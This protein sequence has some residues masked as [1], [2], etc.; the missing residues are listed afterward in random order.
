[1]KTVNPSARAALPPTETPSRPDHRPLR[2]VLEPA[3]AS[4]SLNSSPGSPLAPATRKRRST[5]NSQS[6]APL[7]PSIP[8]KAGV[9]I[10]DGVVKKQRRKRTASQTLVP[11][12]LCI[13]S[14][15]PETPL[16]SSCSL[17]PSTPCSTL[18]TPSLGMCPS[19]ASF[20]RSE[21]RLHCCNS[22]FTFSEFIVHNKD[23]HLGCVPS[24]VSG[25]K[26]LMS[27]LLTDTVFTSQQTRR[28]AN[29][30]N[31]ALP[32]KRHGLQRSHVL[33][34]PSKGSSDLPLSRSTSFITD[35]DDDEDDDSLPPLIQAH[36]DSTSVP[37]EDSV[38]HIDVIQWTRPP[39]PQETGSLFSAMLLKSSF[40]KSS[41]LGSSKALKD[42][43]PMLPPPLL[44]SLSNLST[45][46][47]VSSTNSLYNFFCDSPRLE[48]SISSARYEYSCED[49]VLLTSTPQPTSCNDPSHAHGFNV[50]PCLNTTAKTGPCESPATVSAQHTPCSTESLLETPVLQPGTMNMASISSAESVQQSGS[51]GNAL[52]TG[53]RQRV[54]PETP[55]SKSKRMSAN[56]SPSKKN[57]TKSNAVAG[58]TSNTVTPGSG[59]PS[60]RK[61]PIASKDMKALAVT[62]AALELRRKLLLGD[63]IASVCEAAVVEAA[64]TAAAAAAAA[65]AAG[66]ELIEVK[67]EGARFD[68]DRE[69][70]T[71][72]IR[73]GMV[74]DIKPVGLGAANINRRNS[75]R[76]SV[77]S[78][79]SHVALVGNESR[80]DSLQSLESMTSASTANE[81]SLS[82][83]DLLMD[84]DLD[85]NQPADSC[86]NTSTD[87]KGKE[88]CLLEL[89]ESATDQPQ[90]PEAEE[91]AATDGP[92]NALTEA[93]IQ[94]IADISAGSELDVTDGPGP[95][96]E[97]DV[98]TYVMMMM[99]T[100]NFAE[101]VTEGIF[102]GTSDAASM[103]F[104]VEGVKTECGDQWQ[105]LLKFEDADEPD[106][107]EKDAFDTVAFQESMTANDANPV[108]SDILL[109][110]DTIDFSEFPVWDGDEF[111]VAF[112]EAME[113]V[114]S[115]SRVTEPTR[116]EN[117]MALSATLY[118]SANGVVPP[119]QQKQMQMMKYMYGRTT[120]LDAAAS[121][122]VVDTCEV[123][124]V[125]AVKDLMPMEEDVQET[126]EDSGE[127]DHELEQDPNQDEA[128]ARIDGDVVE[129]ETEEE[130][131]EEEE[132]VDLTT[133]V[134]TIDEVTGKKT[135]YCPYPSCSKSYIS[136]PGYRYHLGVH[137]REMFKKG[138]GSKKDIF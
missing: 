56:L 94:A 36:A 74:F 116:P 14:V 84:D 89:P 71:P 24:T 138:R 127:L 15:G 12:S 41:S 6:S 110:A 65:A 88:E 111:D 26:D 64:A 93:E 17:L 43:A 113:L 29:T 55:C 46:S 60:A 120:G 115:E 68:S 9:R 109:G 76:D 57:A 82:T 40:Q 33:R 72:V 66:H 35:D 129:R 80:A 27:A 79:W 92:A 130:D 13:S 4:A 131:E 20:T 77:S 37:P 75:R 16:S 87:G 91:F 22:A 123:M 112:S 51:Q 10:L 101:A 96:S 104:A 118:E 95:T 25:G 86:Q 19:P 100:A 119:E 108:G 44:S 85:P 5:N 136:K 121:N 8:V 105:N 21:A 42:D 69:T 90:T 34:S 102:V 48:S 30:Q 132:P 134:F 45:L 137:K 135:I 3:S 78:A 32:R 2:S 107:Q 114:K 23:A 125:I 58:N 124:S 54:K 50:R 31:R 49:K 106:S 39:C 99:D 62:A 128:Q 70:P 67:K 73:K 61:K 98:M 47:T 59:P 126:T 81:D 53:R 1:M 133:E 122:D 63:S 38:C 97:E 18:L 7:S 103:G 52:N 11:S 117:A 28:N 83:S